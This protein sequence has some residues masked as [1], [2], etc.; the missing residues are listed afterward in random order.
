MSVTAVVDGPAVGLFASGVLIPKMNAK[1]AF[2]GAILPAIV[3][4]HKPLLI[5]G[6]DNQTIWTNSSLIS[7]NNTSHDLTTG[8]KP[9]FIF[10]L[11]HNYQCLFGA[12]VMIII[13]VI[14]SHF[15]KKDNLPVDKMLF[16]PVIHRFLSE[17]SRVTRTYGR[18]QKK[19]E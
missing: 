17:T 13:G 2:G 8:S 4:I 6:C 15:A 7:L 10:R 9:F 16:S 18:S 14:I 3:T 11:S 12:V 19:M 1:G 5:D